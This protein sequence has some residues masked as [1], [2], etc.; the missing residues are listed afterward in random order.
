[1]EEIFRFIGLQPPQKN[2]KSQENAIELEDQESKFQNKIIN[3]LE[4]ADCKNKIIDKAEKFIN[5]K[6]YVKTI[7]DLNLPFNTFERILSKQTVIDTNKIN[8]FLKDTFD[9]DA[10]TV[11]TSTEFKS[12]YLNI[13]DSII[14]LTI[15]NEL[16]NDYNVLLNMVRQYYLIEKA[17]SIYNK[18]WS[19]KY[20]EVQDIPILLPPRIFPLPEKLKINNSDYSYV[21]TND[22]EL[23]LLRNKITTCNK[24]L[25]EFSQFTSED[26]Q[27]VEQEV[28]IHKNEIKV[29]R[30]GFFGRLVD[31]LIGLKSITVD[32]PIIV[33]ANHSPWLLENSATLKLSNETHELFQEL[34]ISVDT[35]PL[36]EITSTVQKELKETSN[37]YNEIANVP[38]MSEYLRIGSTWIENNPDVK[39]MNKSF[40]SI[41]TLPEFGSFRALGVAPL[42]VVK[43][44]IQK[45]EAGEI[46]HIENVLKSEEK[47]RVHRRTKKT[48]EIFIIETEINEETERDLQSTERFELQ[49]ES[50]RTIK[51]ESKFEADLSV[52]YGGFGVSV[53]ASTKYA[54]SDSEEVSAKS[55]REY[56][57]EITERSISKI[58]QRVREERTKKT[59][60]EFEEIN[61]HGFKANNLGHTVGIYRWIDKYYKAQIF[62]YGDRLMFEFFVPEPAAFLIQTQRLKHNCRIN[63]PTAPE[64]KDKNGTMRPLKASD[65]TEYNYLE[66][67]SRY[68]VKEY[69]PP[70][71]VQ[72]QVNFSK[73]TTKEATSDTESSKS[74]KENTISPQHEIMAENIKIPDGYKAMSAFC[75][76]T[77]SPDIFEHMFR[78]RYSKGVNSIDYILFLYNYETYWPTVV[79][80]GVK[81]QKY[82]KLNR[83]ILNNNPNDYW[84]VNIGYASFILW[85][86]E[87][88][89]PLSFAT[90]H[91]GSA[92]LNLEI[93]CIR[94]FDHL[95]NWKT[96]IYNSIM[97]SYYEMRSK[98]EERLASNEIE[99]GVNISGRNPE[100]NRQL[101]KDELKKGSLFLLTQ[102]V[103]PHFD[104]VGSVV[105]SESDGYGYPQIDF[106]EVQREAPYI[107]FLE[108]SFEWDQMMYSFYPY[109]YSRKE[110][111]QDRLL[112]NDNDPLFTEFLKSGMARVVVPVRP[113]YEDA[114][115]YFLSTNQFNQSEKMSSVTSPKYVSIV[116]R[117]KEKHG[118]YY[119]KGVGT[120][121]IKKDSPSE[122]IGQNTKFNKKDVDRE[123]FIQGNR[124]RIQ[125]VDED[126]QKLTLTEVFKIDDSDLTGSTYALGIYFYDEPWEVK[127]PTSLVYL[128]QGEVKLPNFKDNG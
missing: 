54:T 123:I 98:A 19:L 88:N 110:K 36:T 128:E 57:K 102:K 69:E 47:E 30:E 84:G 46:A 48:E 1:M 126:A 112:T 124:Y 76:V 113:F 29:P 89:L 39:N 90:T 114:I 64:I 59:I 27:S 4:G 41:D 118:I 5:S 62:N 58:Q 66:W 40:S 106:Y 56:A 83:G 67:I 50:E 15:L 42:L 79:S 92:S 38:P 120:I 60:E 26:F 23:K 73:K 14:A 95:D 11:V 72:T 96:K 71:P 91:F 31:T 33:K 55:A 87:G 70:P 99:E 34:K 6:N 101:E 80:L 8:E 37:K 100:I 51:E 111:W 97:Q 24:S 68:E 45:Y 127:V 109:F 107:Q 115:I 85:G 13:K 108:Q 2:Q 35:M 3:L 21:N 86:E 22:E 119:S 25:E 44:D 53:S 78:Y 20:D 28:E 7:D 10:K 9:K 16:S 43:Q 125:T 65:I 75:T 116:Q 94:T 74:S 61:K 81:D 18:P 17:S 121:S 122:V 77:L 52:K 93:Y 104:S 117:L 12:D 49:T 63:F 32:V 103:S 105:T 82:I